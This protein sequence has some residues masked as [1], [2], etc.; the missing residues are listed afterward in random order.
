VQA[1]GG[2]DLVNLSALY[3]GSESGQILQGF[4]QFSQSF[5]LSLIASL[6]VQPHRKMDA[7]LQVVRRFALFASKAFCI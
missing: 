1:V 6:L 5:P 2:K 4:G 3:P 7:R